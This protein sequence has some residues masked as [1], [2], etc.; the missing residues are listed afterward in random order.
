[1]TR[2][3]VS[4]ISP[5]AHAYC[6]EQFDKV[7]SLGPFTTF[8]INETR[9]LFPSTMGGADWA[10]VAFDPKLGY[11]FANASNLGQTGKMV[12]AAPGSPMPFRNQGGTRALMIRTAIP[13][14]SRLGVNYPRL[15]RTPATWFGG[16]RW[17]RTTSWKR[18]D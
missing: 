18:R 5:E 15:I 9:L 10:G 2:D 6:L 12:A 7:K 11:V 1:M 16:F 14:I 4:N 17:D 13:A 3:E 8:S